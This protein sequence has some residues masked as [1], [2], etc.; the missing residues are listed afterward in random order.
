MKIT[1]EMIRVPNISF[2]FFVCFLQ[3][4][5]THQCKPCAHLL[6]SPL[7]RVALRVS[8]GLRKDVASPDRPCGGTRHDAGERYVGLVKVR[9]TARLLNKKLTKKC[10]LARGNYQ[11]RFDKHDCFGMLSCGDEV[12]TR[13][14]NALSSGVGMFK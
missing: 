9:S 7:F 12:L 3:N 5:K 8:L 6:A 1:L 11:Q 14:L 2:E 10:V 4:K 13:D